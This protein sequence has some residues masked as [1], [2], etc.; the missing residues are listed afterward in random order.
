MS[1]EA[2]RPARLVDIDLV[3]SEHRVLENLL[4]RHQE[5]LIGGDYAAALGDY[6]DFAR[7][8]RRHIRLENDVLLPAYAVLGNLPRAGKPDF[9]YEEHEKII[10]EVDAIHAV[11][12]NLS[13][14]TPRRAIVYLIEKELR[15]KVLMEHHERRENETM[16]P[17]LR[18]SLSGGEG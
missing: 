3:E 6:E 1:M 14:G 13:S 5:A 10:R 11:V 18:G 12:R 2:K 9:F 16:L 15:L 17:I 8:V 4:I 7:H